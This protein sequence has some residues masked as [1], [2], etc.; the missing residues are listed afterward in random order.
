MGTISTVPAVLDAI[1]VRIR[2]SQD[3]EG[4]QIVDGQPRTTEPDVICIGFTGNPG[5]S[6]VESTRTVEQL[7][8]QPDREQYEIT[9]LASSWRGATDPVAVRD[10]AYELVDA[11]AAELA[12]DPRLG[13]LVTEC[14]ISADRF[15]QEQTSKGPT[16]T[17]MFTVTIDAFTR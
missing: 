17:V 2:A 7:Q 3:L 16:A 15:A 10:R 4:V 14:R 8:R 5:E 13:G 12:K 11:V 1:L 9:C 6:S